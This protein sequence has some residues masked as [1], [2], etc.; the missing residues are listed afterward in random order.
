MLKGVG[1]WL[2]ITLLI[3]F[4]IFG[5]IFGYASGFKGIMMAFYFCLGFGAF[6]AIISVFTLGIVL[7]NK[8]PVEF[9][10][11]QDCIIMKNRS[12]RAKTTHRLAIILG[13][14]GRSATTTGAGLIA[15]SKEIQTVQW[16][17]IK[18]VTVFPEEKV[19]GLKL[20]FVQTMHVFCTEQNFQ[21]V[22]E[23]IREKTKL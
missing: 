19:I 2:A 5:S 8:N 1:I 21:H 12:E 17:E 13:V 16:N 15:A 18:S 6:M 14:L 10:I 3:C 11:Q 22:V 9:I 4:V 20:S 23:L 7:G